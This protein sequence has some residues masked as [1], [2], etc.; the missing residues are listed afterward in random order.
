MN[1]EAKA[2]RSLKK[3]IIYIFSGS[4]LVALLGFGALKAYLPIYLKFFQPPREPDY[5]EYVTGV[6]DIFYVARINDGLFRGSDPCDGLG[7]LKKLG[8]RTII[9]LRYLKANDYGD[10]A[11]KAGFNYFW[12]PFR[13]SDSPEREQV[14][15]FLEI[16]NNPR[17]QPV[18]FH[19]TQGID[20]TGLMAGIY[21]IEHDGWSNDKAF[22]EMNYFGHARIW[23]EVEEVLKRYPEW[24]D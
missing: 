12:L 21:R 19:C 6:N 22:A 15:K 2:K 10:Q 14:E 4:V 18:F 7:D 9:N 1:D 5:A 23:R 11:E 8:I 3:L 24:E 17:H 20:R 13:P 16:V